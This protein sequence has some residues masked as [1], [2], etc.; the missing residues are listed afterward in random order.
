MQEVNQ[1]VTE[2]LQKGFIRPS[3]FPYASSVIFVAKKD[4]SLRMCVDYRALNKITIK[5]RYPLPR[6]D[7][8]LD[9]LKGAEVFFKLDLASGY[10]QIQ[11]AEGDEQ[12]TAFKTRL[13]L[14]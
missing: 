7:E 5:N 6:I 2:L 12:K 8:I 1:Q 10:H 3:K 4:G 14:F 9:R 11:I 13:G